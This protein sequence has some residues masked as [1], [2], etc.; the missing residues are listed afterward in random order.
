M[1]FLTC[2]GGKTLFLIIGPH[3]KTADQM[4]LASCKA[5]ISAIYPEAEF[6]DM[7]YPQL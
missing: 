6:Q 7:N 4:D 1:Y 5:K 3:G 2:S